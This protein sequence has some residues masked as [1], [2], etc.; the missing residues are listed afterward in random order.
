MANQDIDILRQYSLDM[1]WFF[2]NIKKLKQE[3]KENYVAISK[4]KVIAHAKNM[5]DL[6]SKLEKSDIETKNSVIQ[7][8][9]SEDLLALL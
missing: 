2:N 1:Q 7:F 9:P 5:E 6:K 4:S 3:Y 8:V